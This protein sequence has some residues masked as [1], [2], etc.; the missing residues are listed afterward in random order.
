[1][2]MAW[3]SIFSDGLAESNSAVSGLSVGSN[4]VFEPAEAVG[5]A[6][7]DLRFSGD[8]VV[9]GDG[10]GRGALLGETLEVISS[11]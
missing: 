11:T 7:L 6:V 3:S 5:A 9:R 2:R 8:A 10:E 4:G 1:M